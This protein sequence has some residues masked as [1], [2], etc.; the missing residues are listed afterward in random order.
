M[1]AEREELRSM[2]DGLCLDTG[3]SYTLTTG[4]QSSFYFDCKKA[5]L[6]GRALSLISAAF[7]AEAESLPV[8]P[9]AIGGL[10]MGADFIVAAVI[11]RAFESGRP[12]TLGSVVR[13]EPKKHGTKSRIENEL[14]AG[15]G[16][17]VVDDVITSGSSTDTA[18]REFIDS[19]YRLE[20]IVALVDREAGGL[21][22]LQQR[23]GCPTRAIF[24]K[25][26]FPRIA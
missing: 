22:A 25:S 7:L 16:I 13:K 2:M 11:Q 17:M 20:G 14:A 10:T 21:E 18:C 19:G 4:K 3:S 8:F 5:M 26:D 24:R 1:K 15:T 23:Y 9:V 12:M 6:N